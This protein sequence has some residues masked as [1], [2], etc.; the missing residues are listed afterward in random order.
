VKRQ[1]TEFEESKAMNK[2]TIAI[3]ALAFAGASTATADDMAKKAPDAKKA[4][5]P[6]K[7]EPKKM[8]APKPA[9]ELTDMAKGMTGNWTCTGKFTMDG[10]NW[11]D[12]KGANKMTLDLDKFWLKG[13]M[14]MTAG[15]M[16]MK[17]VEYLTYDGAQKKWFRLAMDS[18]GGHET[19]WSADGK[20]WEGEMSMMGMTAKVKTNVEMAPKELKVSSEMSPD[21]K[22]WI[23]G[24]EMTCKK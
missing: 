19:A 10:T 7:E 18:T 21:G 14:T 13:D 22:K 5:E 20:K 9:Q 6:K 3:A 1:R 8:E 2:I 12:F 15:P 11:T 24:F 23:K 17:G 16:K 4:P